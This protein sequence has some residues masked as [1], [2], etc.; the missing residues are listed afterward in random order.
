MIMFGYV[1]FLVFFATFLF[2]E[3]K[4][5]DAE[6][7]DF[8]EM[9]CLTDGVVDIEE[10]IGR[11]EGLCGKKD[12]RVFGFYKIDRKKKELKMEFDKERFSLLA[13]SPEVW[14]FTICKPYNDLGSQKPSTRPKRD[15]PDIWHAPLAMSKSVPCWIWRACKNKQ[16]ACYSKKESACW[17]NSGKSLSEMF[18]HDK[19]KIRCMGCSC[20]TPIGVFRMSGENI[21]RIHTLLQHCSGNVR[22]AVIHGRLGHGKLRDDYYRELLSQTNLLDHISVQLR[23][24]AEYN[25][26]LSICMLALDCTDDAIRV[27]PRDLARHIHYSFEGYE[28]GCYEEDIF[29][30]VFPETSKEIALKHVERLREHMAQ[31]DLYE[32]LT[33]SISAGVAG[34]PEDVK[35]GE[36]SLYR[37]A[38]IAL[39]EAQQAGNRVVGY[40]PE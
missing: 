10:I 16:C 3:I 19:V 9:H 14:A 35:D 1:F 24:A 32:G 27:D 31:K 5:T 38:L 21:S 20:F 39:A 18:K 28:M 34:F 6:L 29:S 12:F 7:K 15:G 23:I 2:W 4:R 17:L 11:L 30:I 40:S 26:P 22:T 25:H 36:G 8:V 37:M 33:I 13:K